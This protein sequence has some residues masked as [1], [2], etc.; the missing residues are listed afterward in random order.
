[1]LASFTSPPPSPTRNTNTPVAPLN[2]VIVAPPPSPHS[3]L[4]LNHLKISQGGLTLVMLCRPRRSARRDSRFDPPLA[5]SGAATP[6]SVR[7]GTRRQLLGQQK[8]K[9]KQKKRMRGSV[10]ASGF[11]G[12]LDTG[13][14]L[15]LHPTRSDMQKT[16]CG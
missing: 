6:R 9:K 8:K 3:K 5:R 14:N 16:L 12:G 7:V 11:S 4:S 2:N 13:C 1:M 10:Q 15:A